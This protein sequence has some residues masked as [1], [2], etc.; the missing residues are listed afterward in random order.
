MLPEWIIEDIADF[1]LFVGKYGYETRVTQTNSKDELVAFIV[2]FL[3]NPKYIKNPYLKAKFVEILFFLTYPVA[4]GVPGEL[5][6]ALN[7]NPLALNHLMSALMS[8]YVDVEQTGASSQFYDKFNVRYNISQIIKTIW[9]NSVH[10]E[11]LHTESVSHR[12]RF[13]RFIN[14]LM[15]DVTY[16]LNESQAKL[17]EIHA[18]QVQMKSAEWQTMT[19]Q[20]R[21]ERE[22]YLRGCERQ[23]GSYVALGNETVHM[24]NYMT[25]E[26]IEPFMT[27]EIV[28]RL[29]AMLDLNLE[30]LVGPKRSELK[31]QNPEKYRF[32]PKQLLCELVDIYLHLGE[33]PEFIAA[34]ARDQRSYNKKWFGKAEEIMQHFMLKP[35]DE[36][37]KLRLFVGKVEEAVRS[38]LEEEEDLGDA[39]EEFM[40]PLMCTL[41]ED[42]V[43]VPTS[44]ITLDRSTIRAHLL[45]ESRDPYNRAPLTMDM[46]KDDP[47]LKAKIQ[48]WKKEKLA[49]KRKERAIG[50]GA[51]DMDTSK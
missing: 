34:V 46:V 12:G 20:Q 47:E 43:F 36:I 4:A 49:Q 35:A 2:T 6:T 42:P 11:Q 14:M 10:R 29:A 28:D 26:L 37:S 7:S 3:K 17:N 25:G 22:G 50:H 15:S 31:V 45:G 48:N 38:G 5:D 8:F 18:V 16:L 27:P 24:L 21:Q 23:A 33:A 30:T 44:G 39:P 1:W 40:D 19:P 13:T 32:D 41:M 9:S 51:T